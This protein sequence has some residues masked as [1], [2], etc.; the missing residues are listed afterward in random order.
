MTN[1]QRFSANVFE[2]T[3]LRPYADRITS[4]L[5]SQSS[6]RT[7]SS[8]KERFEDFARWAQEVERKEGDEVKLLPVEAT[9]LAMYALS[10]DDRGMALSSI[11]SYVSAV[12]TIHHAAG[13]V[14]PTRDAAVK[15]AIARL[16][17]KHAKAQRHARPLSD[18][19]LTKV[20]R[21]LPIPRRG[22]GGHLELPHTASKRS[23]M[24]KALLLSMIEAGMRVYEASVLTWGDVRKE[25]DGS[26]RLLLRTNWTGHREIWVAITADCLKA[27]LDIKPHDADDSYYVFG[28]TPGYISRLLKRMCKE[29][30]IDS[31]DISGETPRATLRR[32]L[33]DNG[34]PLNLRKDRLRI[35]N[36]ARG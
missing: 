9:D 8:L 31:R 34:D 1:R 3:E 32:I 18:S 4:Y 25:P 11:T 33:A 27:L 29:A 15:D 10:L 28:I 35:M 2:I 20:L 6:R 19:E 22:K 36:N 16:R 21:V 12:G 17:A 7:A 24:E 30:G 13:E 26:G 23:R 14:S 5:N